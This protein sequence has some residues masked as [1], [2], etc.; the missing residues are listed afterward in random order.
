MWGT[1]PALIDADEYCVGCEHSTESQADGS[2]H[3]DGCPESARIRATHAA[4][5]SPAN[6]WPA[7]HTADGVLVTPGLWV[8]TNNYRKAQV[9]RYLHA[10]TN[11]NTGTVAH[12]FDTTDCMVDESRMVTVLDGK[13]ADS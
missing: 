13:R 9:T 7:T 10:E 3:Y 11:Q 12:W 6:D 1:D 8:W 5:V 4:A 2:R